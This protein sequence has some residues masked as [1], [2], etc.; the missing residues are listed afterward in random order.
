MAT[1]GGATG[2]GKTH[3]RAAFAVYFGE[4]D[5]R[6][7]SGRVL[8][9]PS[10]QTGELTAIAKAVDIISNESDEKMWTILTDS[11]YSIKA[12]TVWTPNWARRG[13]RKPDGKPVLHQDIIQPTYEKLRQLGTRVAFKHIRS[14][15][16]A[17]PT[18][19]TQA[20]KEWSFNKEVDAACTAV[21][22]KKAE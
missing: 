19:D 6:N 21:L 15:K 1:D 22:T 2:N 20:W 12:L 14:H 4:N 3:C 16:K 9:N 7:C 10:N 8:K 11:D 18:S 5:V 17:P 13:W